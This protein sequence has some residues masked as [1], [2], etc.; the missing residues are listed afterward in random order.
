ME[1]Y[2][3]YWIDIIE[4]MNNS[5]T[6][7]LAWGKAILECIENEEFNIIGEEVVVE[8]KNIVENM[9]KYYWNQ[10]FF[11]QLQQGPNLTDK[12]V[13]YQL[14]NEM[15]NCYKSETKRNIPVW[16]N[17]AKKILIKNKKS[18]N[19]YVKKFVSVA[20][21]NVTH[22]FLN[23]KGQVVPLY[24]LDK[25]KRTISFRVDDSDVLKEYSSILKLLLNYKWAQLLELYN[26]SPKIASKVENS[27]NAKIK[28]SNLSKL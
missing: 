3:K 13:M 1:R 18:Y 25:K 2:I 27:S 17:E 12:P 24:T 15:I 21:T 14:I 11:F 23:L 20:N 4:G 8:H 9:M 19:S 6:Y 28:R 16:F 7:K 10:T 26:K 5:N 22:R